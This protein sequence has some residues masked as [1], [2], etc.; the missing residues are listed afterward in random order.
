MIFDKPHKVQQDWPTQICPGNLF[1]K[2]LKIL[3]FLKKYGRI[4]KIQ[5]DHRL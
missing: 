5:E 2:F 4:S 3:L 1:G